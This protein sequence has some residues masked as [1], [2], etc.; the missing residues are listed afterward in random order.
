MEGD[1]LALEP[2]L[3]RSGFGGCRVE[4]IVRVTRDGAERLT[5]FSYELLP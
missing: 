1:I 2:G 4:D 3:Y 5:G